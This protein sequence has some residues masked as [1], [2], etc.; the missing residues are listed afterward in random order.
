VLIRSSIFALRA[1]T[2]LAFLYCATALYALFAPQA[3]ARHALAALPLWSL[4]AL[5][6]FCVNEV[7]FFF[8][9]RRKVGRH[10][11]LATAAAKLSPAQRKVEFKRAIESVHDPRVFLE[12]WFKGAR[13]EDIGYDNVLQW[14]L[15]A[16]FDA[17]AEPE[18]L[19]A[20][21]EDIIAEAKSYTDAWESRFNVTFQ[22]GFNHKIQSIRLSL[23]PVLTT[24]RPACV[25]LGVGVLYDHLAYSRYRSLGFKHYIPSAESGHR[26]SYPYIG[27]PSS[28]SNSTLTYWYKPCAPLAPGE[29]E[30]LPIVFV[31]GIGAGLKVY[32][33]MITDMCAR[34]PRSAI[35]LLEIPCVAMKLVEKLPVRAE[36]VRDV[37]AMLKNHG[38][39]T[40]ALFAGHSLGTVVV[41]WILHLAPQVCRKVMLIDPVVWLLH[42]PDVAYNFLHR[43]PSNANQWLYNFF[44]CS[45][46]G[47]A[48]FLGRGFVW[49]ENVLWFEDVPAHCEMRVYLAENDMIVNIPKVFEYLTGQD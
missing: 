2:P 39:H 8:Y 6:I 41:S 40:E 44:V 35:Y 1:V 46:P 4:A 42:Y 30:G 17:P 19:Y 7:W 12:G 48:R 25:Y 43:P 26:V 32:R 37:V 34:Y 16:F 45:E 38:G 11:A 10:Q 3:I 49:H 20:L 18:S 14:I 31:H 27:L 5:T 13:L 28:P 24:H 36:L 23:D 21:P 47:I 22:P 9:A 33:T 29:K 15:W